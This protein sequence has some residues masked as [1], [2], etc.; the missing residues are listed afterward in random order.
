MTGML[1]LSPEPAFV[2]EKLCGVKLNIDTIE[3]DV[4]AFKLA[5]FAISLSSWEDGVGKGELGLLYRRSFYFPYNYTLTIK[6]EFFGLNE[7][8]L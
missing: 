7:T 2:V 5:A 8:G 1:L 4:L 3:V 6:S